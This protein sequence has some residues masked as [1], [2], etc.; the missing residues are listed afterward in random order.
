MSSIYDIKV[1]TAQDESKAL[2]AYKGS[3]LLIVNLA[4]KCG[5]TPQYKGLQELYEAYTDKGLTVLGF[6]CNDFGGQEPGS[7]EEIQ[8]FCSLNFGVTFPLFEK[9]KIVGEDKHPLY[10]WL[11][12]HSEP[13]GDVKWN[14]EKF[15]IG[16][17][18]QLLG[19]YSSQ[20]TP[21]DDGLLADIEQALK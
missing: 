20:V 1:T 2:D 19:R 3:A 8:Q 11:T 16:K 7:I 9:V 4:S 12:E 17:D 10:Q 5:F 15:L 13:Q 14:F 18:G 6:P 21:E